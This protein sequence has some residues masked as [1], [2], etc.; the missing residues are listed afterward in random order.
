MLN[1]SS[2]Y[3]SV[4]VSIYYTSGNDI[5]GKVHVSSSY[6]NNILMLIVLEHQ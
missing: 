5:Q 3:L 4:D 6:N 1:P 2:K